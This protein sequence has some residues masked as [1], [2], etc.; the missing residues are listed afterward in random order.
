[1]DEHHDR[2]GTLHRL[3]CPPALHWAVIDKG[4][5]VGARVAG[6]RTSLPLG[7]SPFRAL[8]RQNA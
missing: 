3:H 5:G 8:F 7:C 6:G 1:M 4:I 2:G